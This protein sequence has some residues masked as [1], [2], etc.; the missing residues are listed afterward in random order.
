M[1]PHREPPT[2]ASDESEKVGRKRTLAKGLTLVAGMAILAGLGIV[3]HSMWS[4]EPALGSNESPAEA[5]KR[6]PV[7]LTAAREMT[8]ESTVAVSGSVQAKHFALVSA[9]LPGSLDAVHVDEGDVVEAGKTQLFQTDSLKLTKAV[10]IAR[11]GLQ[12]AEL[13][14]EEKDANLEQV[15]ANREQAEVDLER[16]RA[17]IRENAIP[18]QLFDQQETRWKQ[19]NA[20]VR[21]AEALLALDKSKLEQARLQLT[22]A[23]KDLADSL[24]LAPISG[25]VSQRFMEPGEMAA[26]GTPVVKIEDLSLLEVSVFLPEEHYARVVPGKTEMRINVGGVDLETLRVVY[27]S[28]TVTPKLRTFE[29]KTLIESPPPEVAPGCLAEVVVVLDGRRGVGIPTAAIA[30]RGGN[31]AIF[32]VELQTARML[33]VQ[34]GRS[35][36][37]WTEILDGGLSVGAEVITMGQQLVNDGTP[38]AVAKE[39]SR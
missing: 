31:S 6:I 35:M 11:Q 30:Q 16:Y 28:P 32:V 14:V 13:S 21:H 10:A 3:L 2:T 24:V 33:P 15:L 37:G 26:P 22:I 27:K 4:V 12:V 9:R 5:V 18:R 8:F 20:M 1:Q 25:Q 23:E 29:I 38:V 17:L 36:S 34:T 19:A 39:D 7:V